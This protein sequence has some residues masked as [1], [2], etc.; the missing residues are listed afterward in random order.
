M[1]TRTTPTKTISLPEGRTV[2]FTDR[3]ERAAPAVVFVHGFM[4]CRLSAPPPPA[5]ARVVAIDR[6]GIGGSDPRPGRRI[7][8]WPDD[9]VAVVDALG[10]DRFAVLGHSGGGPFSAACAYAL[11]DR[12]RALGLACAFAPMDRPGATDG[13][14]ARMAKAMP[15]LR[16]APWMARLACSSLPRQYAKDPEQAFEKQFGRDLPDC[17]RRALENATARA[18]LLD[19]A[20]ESTRGGARSLALETQLMF[21]RPWGFDPSSITAPTSLWYGAED[22]LSPVSMGRYL[23]SQIAGSELVVYANEGHMALFTHWDEIVRDLV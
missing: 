5:G 15:M 13:M 22:T 7:V 1:D 19:A 9:V 2:A 20:V 11:G 12:V 18:R 4:A 23:Q 6:P 10:I 3:G 16:R 17:D 8:D 21:S 14:N